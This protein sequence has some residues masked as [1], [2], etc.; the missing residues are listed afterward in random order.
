[1]KFDIKKLYKSTVKT[2][3]QHQVELSIALAAL[4]M[5]AFAPDPEE[6]ESLEEIKEIYRVQIDFLN[7]Q[8][9]ILQSLVKS[10]EPFKNDTKSLAGIDRLFEDNL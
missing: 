1:M 9:A 3:E 6:E 5:V 10:D 4:S 8:I 7:E 2:L